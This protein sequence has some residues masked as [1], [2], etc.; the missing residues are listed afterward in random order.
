WLMLQQERPDDYV[1]AT[2]ETHSVREFCQE[3]FGLLGLDWEQHVVHDS[4]YERPAEV[5][6]L[7]GNPEKARKQ[8][9]W[10]PKVRFKDL[11][12]IMVEADL[13][14]AEHEAQVKNFGK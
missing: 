14:L 10:E 8:L 11:V 3:T 9:G 13:K 7:I 5:D 1:V 6:L 2:N 4:R 12:K